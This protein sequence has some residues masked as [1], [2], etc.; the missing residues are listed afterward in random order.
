MHSI[1]ASINSDP[2]DED[3][4]PVKRQRLLCDEVD[5]APDILQDESLDKSVGEILG[6]AGET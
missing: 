5:N 6:I 1:G 2:S 3:D 4:S